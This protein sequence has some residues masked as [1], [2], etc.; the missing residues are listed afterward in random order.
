MEV[1]GPPLYPIWVTMKG[2]LLH[3]WHE[4]IFRMIGNCIGRTLEV[5]QRTI[6]QEVLEEGRIKVVLE[7]VEALPILV[8]LW[9]EEIK[10]FVRIEGGGEIESLEEA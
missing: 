3:A 9:V 4:D 8:P 7:T 5:D 1:L 2:V 10:F 6:S